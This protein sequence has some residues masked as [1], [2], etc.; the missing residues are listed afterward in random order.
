[1]TEAGDSAIAFDRHP[2]NAEVHHFGAPNHRFG[3]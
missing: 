1:M 2:D 3:S